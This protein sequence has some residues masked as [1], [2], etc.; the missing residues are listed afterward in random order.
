VLPISLTV[1]ACLFAAQRFGTGTVGKLF[2]PICAVWFGALALGGISHIVEHPGI[3][4]A[5]SP[6]YA[7]SFAVEHPIITFLALSGVVLTITGVEALYADM[8]HFGRTAIARAWFFLV[9]PALTLN[10]MGQGALILETPSSIENPFFLLFPEWALIPMVA[11][12]TAATVIA[13]QAVISGAFSVSRQAVQLG[14]LPRLTIRHTSMAEVGQVYVPAINWAV[15]AAV[16]ALVLAFRTS[17]NLAA[18]YGI[19][20]TATLAIDTI[21]YFTVTRSRSRRPLW[22]IT[23]GCGLFLIMDLTFFSANLPKFL[24]GGWFPIVI[25]LGIFSVFMTWSKGRDLV[26]AARTEDEGPL[27]AFVEEIH[28][29][30]APIQRVPGT[31]IFLNA[32][33]QTTPLA[34]RANVEHNHT[35]HESVV[36]VSIDVQSVPHVP[37]EEGV[38]VDDLGYADDGIFHVSVRYGFQDEV[39]VPAALSCAAAMGPERE[40]DLEEASYFVSRISLRRGGQNGAMP[41]WRKALFLTLARNAANPIEYFNLPIDRTVVMGG[42]ITI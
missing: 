24:E 21:L 33:P 37:A 4:A 12:A 34:L 22:L 11:L 38:A 15:L 6:T 20:V 40:L 1:L 16:V 2:G 14:F 5:L 26:T 3:L 36:I 27:R 39:D 23:A 35:L 41:G 29:G 31:A 28:D 18:A 10:Y 9:F 17:E 7:V 30:R 25:A 13:S 8:G 42:H 32:N 19:A